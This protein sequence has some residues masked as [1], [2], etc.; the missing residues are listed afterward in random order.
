MHNRPR[1]KKNPPEGF[2]S[3]NNAN[4]FTKSN[5]RYTDVIIPNVSNGKSVNSARSRNNT[6]LITR[7]YSE[8]VGNDMVENMLLQRD[9]IVD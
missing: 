4:D 9:Y 2:F 5:L 8:P 6:F 7:A 1:N 3:A